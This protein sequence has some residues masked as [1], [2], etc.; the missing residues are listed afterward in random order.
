[1]LYSLRVTDALG[2]LNVSLSVIYETDVGAWRRRECPGDA[3]PGKPG[4]PPRR[5]PAIILHRIDQKFLISSV[6][7]D[8]SRDFGGRVWT[9]PRGRAISLPRRPDPSED[10]QAHGRRRGAGRRP[11]PRAG[12]S[13]VHGFNARGLPA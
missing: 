1:T 7:A 3:P 12:S 10:P 13:P 2:V 9:R 5:T 4:R 6:N 8:Q 11:H